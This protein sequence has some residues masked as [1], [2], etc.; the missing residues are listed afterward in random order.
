[1]KL[2]IIV[3]IYN[4]EKFL[5]RCLD[6]LL[7]QGLNAG[8]YEVICV[9]DGS[10]DNCAT[11]LAEYQQKNPDIFKIIT[12]KNQGIGAARNTGMKVAKGEWITFV[13]SDDYI[14]DD[15]YKYILSHFCEKEVDVLQF[16][17]ILAYT[18]GLSFYDPDAKPDGKIIFDGDGADAYNKMS[19]SYVW[20][21]F[22]RHDF[23]KKYGILFESAFMEDEPFN[24]EVFCHSPHLRIVTSQIYRYEQGNPYSTLSNINKEKVKKQL[25]WLLPIIEKLNLYLKEGEGTLT[26]AARR[27]INSCLRHYYNKMLKA[28]LT[29]TEWK[30]CTR[31]IK[32]MPIYKVDVSYES[33]LLGKTITRLKNWS[34]HSYL[35]YLFTAFLLNTVF[36][37]FVRPRIVSSYTK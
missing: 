34:S 21:K 15:G 10:P 16:G 24:F 26:L 8:E 5:P 1:M 23:L 28:R 35:I 9:N 30:E 18:D 4:V 17:C 29:I 14:I 32:K 11:I 19:M 13:D 12:Q 2:S 33:S 37:R 36:R 3:P 31:Q 7:R 20:S 6:S 27:D 25:K 22:Y